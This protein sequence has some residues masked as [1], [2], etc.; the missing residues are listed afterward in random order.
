MFIGKTVPKTDIPEGC[1]K[2]YVQ[3]V[4]SQHDLVYLKSNEINNSLS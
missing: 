1:N 2:K 4:E 3:V